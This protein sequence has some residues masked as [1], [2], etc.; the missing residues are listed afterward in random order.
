MYLTLKIQLKNIKP[1]IWRRVVVSDEL[2][3]HQLHHVLQI[4]F[5]WSGTHLYK[6]DINGFEI[7]RENE[8]EP[9]ELN[10]VEV[11]LNN[12][13]LEEKLSFDYTYDFGD[14]WE[15]KI[16]IEKITELGPDYP[17]CLAGKRNAPPED[18]GGGWAY[19]DLMNKMKL[20]KLPKELKEWLGDYELAFF[21][22]DETNDILSDPDIMEDDYL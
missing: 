21:D 5:G 17:I 16:T 11:K 2:T 10:S 20:S 3:F 4:S 14:D 12:Y 6:F 19:E 13:P 7:E 22:L 15:H 18:C 8:F 9:A 1:A